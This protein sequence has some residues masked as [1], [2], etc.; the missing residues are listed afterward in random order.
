MMK[1]EKLE[2]ARAKDLNKKLSSDESPRSKSI[3]Y[4]IIVSFMAPVLLASGSNAHGQLA[5]GTLQDSHTFSRCSFSGYPPGVLPPTASRIVQI[6]CGAN[7]A[8]VLLDGDERQIWGCGDGSKGQLG[9]SCLYNTQSGTG[10]GSSSSTS[11]FKRISLSNSRDSHIL[12]GRF[13]RLVAACWETTYVVFSS[14]G[15]GDVLVS[16]GADDF[17][18]LGIGGGP[19]NKASESKGKRPIKSMSQFPWHVVE[20][21]H[22]R[23]EGGHPIHPS[24]IAIQSLIAGPHHVIA[25]IEASRKHRL[26]TPGMNNRFTV[27]WGASR[28][29]QLG[30]VLDTGIKPAKPIA[31]ID[32]PRLIPLPTLD[33]HSV[34][35]GNQHTIF[36]H[37]SGR[38]SGLGSNRK[39]QLQGIEGAKEVAAV[40]CTWHGTYLVLQ[41][42]ILATGIGSKGQLGRVSNG[43]DD[44]AP[45]DFP[46]ALTAA[47]RL[48]QIACGSEHVLAL[49]ETAEGQLSPGMPDHTEVWGWG[50]N[51]HGNLGIGTTDDVALPTKIWPTSEAPNDR[52]VG[53]W[54]GCGTS[55]IAINIENASETVVR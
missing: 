13:P 16:M 33:I 40:H 3:S 4:R 9:S 34:G 22:L 6:A 8:V 51:E 20:L 18:D 10:E 15:R 52:V 43:V 29:G 17:G 35:L 37:D 38:C 30:E 54:A 32:H 21:D 12:E 55:W 26:A 44:L 19:G 46:S 42:S 2:G 53:I 41:S 11:V 48:L 31:C 39:G 5:N 27:G 47:C 1:V 23:L 14:A 36:L 45:V 25:V 7:H 24:T 49:F 50:W 28:H